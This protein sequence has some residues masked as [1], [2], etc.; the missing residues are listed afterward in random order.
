M[1]EYDVLAKVEQALFTP[2]QKANITSAARDLVG[3]ER[4]GQAGTVVLN[5]LMTRRDFFAAAALT[6]L[7]TI[8]YQ[9]WQ[10]DSARAQRAYGYADAMLEAREKPSGARESA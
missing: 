6:G 1:D 3:E 7:I 4:S 10:N 5:E 2:K 9:N 8:G